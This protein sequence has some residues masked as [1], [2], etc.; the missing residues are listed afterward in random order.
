MTLEPNVD[1]VLSAAQ[2]SWISK[3][4]IAG[5][6]H[7]VSHL[8][9]RIRNFVANPFGGRGESLVFYAGAGGYG[10]QLLAIPVVKLLADIGYEVTVLVDPGNQP[11]WSGLPFVRAIHALP[12]PYATLKLFQRHA[13]LQEITNIDEHPDQQHP[14]DAMLHR[15]G[16]DPRTIAAGLKVVPPE[17]SPEES[18]EAE[19]L[20]NGRPLALYQM[21]GSGENRRLTPSASRTLLLKLAELVPELFWVGIYDHHIPGDYYAPLPTDAPNNVQLFTFPTIRQLFAVAQRCV[22][23][24]SIDSLLV[25]LLGSFGKPCVGLWGPLPP[26]LRVRYYQKHVPIWNQS[27]C[28]IA[29]CLR[30]KPTLEKCPTDARVA[31]MCLCLKDVDAAQVAA[32]VRSLV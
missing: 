26:E 29:P 4:E 16:I 10:D 24:V 17:I 15:V 21:G 19:R 32:A 27:A 6:M 14:V 2:F 13:L 25:H 31:G 20:V 28:Q 5:A 3:S 12:V 22:V 7:R 30:Y 11:C 8:E 9:S 18:A 23:G 1:Y